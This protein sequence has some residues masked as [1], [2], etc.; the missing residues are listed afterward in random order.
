MVDAG[1]RRSA[2]P[3]SG[4]GAVDL[5]VHPAG[6]AAAA[7]RRRAP[8]PIRTAIASV[9]FAHKF[10]QYT[11]PVVAKGLEDT[12]F[13]RDVLLLSANEVG[14]DLRYR[15]RTV[16][17][18]HAENLH[19]LSRWPY[20]MTAG[21]TH[22]TKRGEDARARINVIAERPDE[23]R[24]QSRSGRRSTSGAP[25]AARATLG[26][27]IATTSG[28]SIRRWSARGRPNALDAPVPAVGAASV[29]RAHADASWS[30]R[31][32]RRSG[33]RRGC[34]RTPSTKR[35]WRDSSRRCWAAIAP[36]RFSPRSC[37]CSGALAWFGMLGSL[38]QLVL[39][40]GAP[41]VPDIYQGSELWNFSLVDPDNRQ[42]VDLRC[43]GDCWPARVAADS[44]SAG[45][46]ARWPDGRVKLFTLAERC[47]CAARTGSLFAGEYEPLGGDDD[48]HL[49]AFTRRDG[50]Q[51]LVVAVP[52]FV[53]R[54]CAARR[55]AR[56]AWNGGARPASASGASR[57][58]RLVNVFT[59]GDRAGRLSRRAVA[60]RRHRVPVVARRD[61][62][63]QR[64]TKNED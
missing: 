35:G 45:P 36:R 62:V 22:D 42:P 15:T 58:A 38:A 7:V 32:R 50:D 47:A 49:I 8:R 24:A 17:E 46:A 33:T 61:A 11:A 30:R 60:A 51:E 2:P 18:F 64:R 23:W 12:A 9:A 25:D 55:S 28:C 43:D 4:A 10:Q 29:R 13:Y 27:R 34:T 56:S 31:S 5:R 59:G 54:C 52:R 63:R 26:A 44:A 1:D 57:A 6:A 40:L 16:S 53:A 19:R 41:G 21:S 20:E 39:R 3:Q 48:P 14:G 37:R